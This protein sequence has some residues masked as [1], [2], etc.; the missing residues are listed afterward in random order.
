MKAFRVVASIALLVLVLAA[1]AQAAPTVA[2]ALEYFNSKGADQSR[3][4][5]EMQPEAPLGAV[6]GQTA[7]GSANYVASPAQPELQMIVYN[8]DL[9]IAVDDPTKSMADIQ[10]LAANMGGLVVSTNLYKTQTGQGVE[11]PVAYVSIRVPAD[12]LNDALDQIKALTGDTTK[13][14]ITENV[15]GQ[16]IT[17]TYTDLKSRLKNLEEAQ[18][19]LASFYKNATKT[20]DVLAIYNQKKDIEQQI[21]VLKG[22]IQYYDQATAKSLIN[23]TLQAKE[24][25]AP[26]TVAGWEP[27]GIAADALQS[28]VDTLKGLGTVLI[29]FGIYVLPLL[30]L[31]GVPAYF[32]IRAITRKT[33]KVQMAGIPPL[34]PTA[35]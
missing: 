17:Q 14:V 32:I 13:Y 21:E 22:Q 16:D 10:K 29:W 11:V 19:E 15:T 34:P 3:S 24:T 33:R 18:V 8:A 5:A 31:I 26:I 30:V 1:C 7:A 9:E 28:L 4:S 12:K 35:P 23:V 25:I 20:E 6:T 27:K 2:P